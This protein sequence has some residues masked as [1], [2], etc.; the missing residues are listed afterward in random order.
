MTDAIP[1]DCCP[2]CG[3]DDPYRK[4]YD[5]KGRQRYYCRNCEKTWTQET[6]DTANTKAS[7]IAAAVSAVLHGECTAWTAA[8][9][10]NVRVVSV[11]RRLAEPDPEVANAE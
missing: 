5:P 2:Y 4:G 6:W 1:H 9:R 3:A 10:F 11:L 7:R 8:R